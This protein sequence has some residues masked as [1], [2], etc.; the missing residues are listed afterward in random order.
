[1]NDTSPEIAELVRQR[2]MARSGSERFVMG[3]RMFD[4]ARAM[5]LASLPAGLPADELKRRLFQRVYGWP[6]PF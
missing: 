6:A 3:T 1:M 4:S 5:V 2:L